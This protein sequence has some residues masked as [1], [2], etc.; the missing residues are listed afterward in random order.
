M[1]LVSDWF[2]SNKLSLNLAKT[3]YMSYWLASDK[4]RLDEVR[5]H[6][7]LFEQSFTVSSWLVYLLVD[8]TLLMHGRAASVSWDEQKHF[9]YAQ[10]VR[11]RNCTAP[12]D[13]APWWIIHMS[14]DPSRR[15]AEMTERKLSACRSHI[16]GG[17]AENDGHEIAGHEFARHTVRIISTED[18]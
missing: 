14:R 15:L 17:G 16:G 12:S 18:T 1:N 9:F 4:M 10:S 7:W 2:V 5:W 8:T 6:L 13:A 3:C 11:W